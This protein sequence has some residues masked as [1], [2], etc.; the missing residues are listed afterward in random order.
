MRNLIIALI[1]SITTACGAQ[2][3]AAISFFEYRHLG[4]IGGD[5]HTYKVEVAGDSATFSTEG[6][7]YRSD[8]TL[9]CPMTASELE[10]LNKICAD[11]NILSWD[12]YH[13]IDREVLDGSGFSLYVKFSDGKSVSAHGMNATPGGFGGFRRQMYELLRPKVDAL[14]AERQNARIL[15]DGA[16]RLQEAEITFFNKED[17]KDTYTLNVDRIDK[18][19]CRLKIEIKSATGEYFNTGE[20]EIVFCAANGNDDIVELLKLIVNHKVTA[21]KMGDHNDPDNPD[22][23]WYA[24]NIRFDNWEYIFTRGT[25]HPDGYNGFRTDFLLWLRQLAEKLRS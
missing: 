8:D 10:Q 22:A 9:S 2:Q 17:D 5:S 4:T 14:M 12:G 16:Q 7:L 11:N 25:L 24:I 15:H 19:S 1:M 21:W 18:D 20:E 3:Y 23:E 6:M 13:G